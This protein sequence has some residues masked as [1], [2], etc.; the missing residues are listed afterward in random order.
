MLPEVV[1]ID[2]RLE[3]GAELW[4]LAVVLAP[5]VRRLERETVLMA[6]DVDTCAGVAVLPPRATRTRVLVQDHERQ[7][8]LL[9]SDAGQDPAH[10]TTDHNDGRRDLL[11][12]RDR[13]TPGDLPAVRTL[14][15]QVVEEKT[16]Q[17][18]LY[19]ASA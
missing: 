6:P 4:L 9:E 7:T 12:R 17:S 19:G 16:G 15:L 1:F 2:H 13:V 8:R 10:T 3:V 18:L 5:Q 14:E 11:R